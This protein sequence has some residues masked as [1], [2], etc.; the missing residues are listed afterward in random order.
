MIFADFFV[1]LHEVCTKTQDFT[2]PQKSYDQDKFSRRIGE[3]Q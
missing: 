2:N 1:T 3:W